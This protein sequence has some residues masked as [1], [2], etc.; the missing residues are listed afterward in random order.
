MLG[1]LKSWMQRHEF[2]SLADF[3]G[4]MSQEKAGNP[5]VYERTQFMRYFG[6]EKDVT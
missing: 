1:D 6:G 4:R 5:A 2:Q 3:R